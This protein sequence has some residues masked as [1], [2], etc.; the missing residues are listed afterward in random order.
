MDKFIERIFRFIEMIGIT[1]LIKA[2]IV[3]VYPLAGDIAV[4]ILTSL[5]ALY[6]INPLYNYCQETLTKDAKSIKTA[7]VGVSVTVLL[8]LFIQLVWLNPL[9]S[10]TSDLLKSTVSRPQTKTAPGLEKPLGTH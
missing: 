7:A 9:V 1:A 5:T 4:S 3:P 10:T 2:V 8:F 6:L